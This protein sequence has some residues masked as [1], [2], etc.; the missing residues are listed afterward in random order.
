MKEANLGAL[1]EPMIW[2]YVREV[3]RFIP[4]STWLTFAEVFPHVWAASAF[5]GAFGETLTV[6]NVK[7]HLENNEAWLEVCLA[8][9]LVHL[10]LLTTLTFYAHLGYGR[11][12][13]EL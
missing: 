12:T 3:Y 10:P 1:V 13:Q 7:M 8:D 11:T 9:E 6:P 2:T 5:K 4:Y